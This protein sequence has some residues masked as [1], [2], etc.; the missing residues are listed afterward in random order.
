MQPSEGCAL[1]RLASERKNG[2]ALPQSPDRHVWALNPARTRPVSLSVESPA[3]VE[4]AT[5]TFVGSR[6][7]PLSYGDML[8]G[9]GNRME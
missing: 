1:V 7:N 8:D 3:G 9:L 6:S 5:P 4:P 2:E